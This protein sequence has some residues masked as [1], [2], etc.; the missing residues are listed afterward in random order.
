MQLN[1]VDLCGYKFQEKKEARKGAG[2]EDEKEPQFIS[3]Y[4]FEFIFDS[5]PTNLDTIACIAC[6][7]INHI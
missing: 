6:H 1:D 4:I 7:F 3:T 2:A 5:M